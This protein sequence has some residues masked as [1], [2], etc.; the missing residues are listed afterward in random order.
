[1]FAAIPRLLRNGRDAIYW[2]LLGAALDAGGVDVAL[3][4]NV[5]LN[6]YPG[7]PFT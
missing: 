2:P 5:V 4:E 1:V 7:G 3:D 6:G